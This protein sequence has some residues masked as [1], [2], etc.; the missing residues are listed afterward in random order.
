M[1]YVLSPNYK[2]KRLDY[3]K[4]KFAHAPEIKSL[5]K[6]ETFILVKQGKKDFIINLE[7]YQFLKFLKTPQ[8]LNAL[9]LQ[10]PEEPE[11][12]EFLQKML[13]RGVL[14]KATKLSDFS[15]YN[16]EKLR[17]EVGDKVGEYKI[18]ELLTEKK[19]TEIYIAKYQERVIIKALKIP[20]YLKEK[21]IKLLKTNFSKEFKLMEKLP[22]NSA[23]AQLI[24][25]SE[26]EG[27]GIIKFIEGQTLSKFLRKKGHEPKIKIY[28]IQQIIEALAFLHSHQIIHGDLHHKNIM[29]STSNKITI[30]DFGLAH[31]Q[32]ESSTEKLR[33]G[34]ID[35]YLPP[36]RIN[37]S[38]FQILGKPADFTSDIYQLGILIYL[39]I[40]DKFP[41]LGFTWDVLYDA[42]QK[43]K[44]DYSL[45]NKGYELFIPIIKKCLNK[46]PVNRYQHAA[47]INLTFNN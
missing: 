21:K 31:N 4:K 19:K 23:L 11:L 16:K 46:E 10:F 7:I 37:K 27:Y 32:I 47:V 22:K 24:K 12:A 13:K 29:V 40:F 5:D 6:E 26:K 36:E 9:K 30:L 18:T 35:V 15:S 25:F 44:V 17:F 39:I 8:T 42:I 33:K 45:K 28:L 20:E 3:L 34:G 43:G 41:F 2:L 14:I 1:G 38:S